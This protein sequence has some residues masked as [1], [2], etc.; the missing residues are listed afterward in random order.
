MNDATEI[1]ILKKRIAYL[2]SILSAHNISFDAPDV[3][4][5][6]SIIVPISAVISPT[7]ARFF[8]SLFHGRSDVYAKR[9]VMKNGKAGYF[10]VCENLWRYGVCPKADR[11]KVKCASCPNRSWAPLNQRA[12]MAHLTGEKS[13]GSDV[14]GI[15]P[16]LPDDTCRFLVFD[17]DDHEASPRHGVAGGCGCFAPNLQPRTQCALLR[18]TFPFRQRRTCLAV[19]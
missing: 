14:I 15:Y 9:A 7:H 2:E 1:Y 19:F 12:L 5:N 18:R 11:Q 10:P 4:S 16:L 13:D 6:Q 3:P 8:Y 17:F